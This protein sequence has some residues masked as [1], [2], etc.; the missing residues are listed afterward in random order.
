MWADLLLG[1]KGWQEACQRLS[2]WCKVATGREGLAEGLPA[3][4][5]PVQ[6][7]YWAGKAGSMACYSLSAHWA[8][9]YWAGKPGRVPATG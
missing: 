3:P 7:C 9:Y 8:S 5:C 2:A 1:G 6:S 4:K